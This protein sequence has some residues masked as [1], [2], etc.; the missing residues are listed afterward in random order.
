MILALDKHIPREVLLEISNEIHGIKIGLPFV[1]DVGLIK[2]K[3][4]L[5]DIKLEEIIIDFKLADIGF[6][7]KQIV[8]R[9]SFADAFI[10]HSFVGIEGAL[11]ELKTFL[12][13]QRK[14]LYLVAAMSHRGWNN[15]FNNYIK[16]IIQKIEPKG[17]VVGATRLDTIREFRFMFPKI[18]IISPGVGTQGA[19]YGDAICAGGDYE[20]VGRSVYNSPDPINEIRKIN[21]IIR[22]KVMSC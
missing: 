12:D 20:I 3:E 21:E 17:I 2:L 15:E 22:N 19:N 9:L 7:M 4:I 14:N 10:A 13:S 8:E 6:V 16:Q 1:L 5:N 18:T 11:D